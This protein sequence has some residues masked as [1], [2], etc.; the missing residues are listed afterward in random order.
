MDAYG[1][2]PL[3]RARLARGLTLL[4]V[5]ER[6]RLGPRVLA[7]LENGDFE[8]LHGG[9]Y[10]RA[11]VRAYAEAVGLNPDEVLDAIK[12]RLP[13]ARDPFDRAF[14]EEDTRRSQRV[15][16]SFRLFDPLTRIRRD[17]ARTQGDVVRRPA[18]S[19]AAWQR[20]A[21]LMAIPDVPWRRYGAAVVDALA[22]T[23]FFLALLA[24][25][26]AAS[27]VSLWAVTRD[28]SIPVGI[29]LALATAAYFAL[30]A[31]LAGRTLGEIAVGMPRVMRGRVELTA[32][33]RR[34]LDVFLEE[35]S[36]LVDLLVRRMRPPT[37]SV[38]PET[39]RA[40]SR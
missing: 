13:L 32:L 5:A 6:T 27:G 34:G 39:T 30:F 31:G 4:Q 24:S 15:R 25:T 2:N 16:R 1:L 28:A 18:R 26:A 19:A 40:T 14:H 35:A 38:R 12:D 22:L 11:Q 3:R 37:E 36:I 23:V 10:A 20:A 21:S 9:I 7:A 29:V 33:G 8:T 17:D